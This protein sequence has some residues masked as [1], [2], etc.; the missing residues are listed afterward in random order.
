MDILILSGLA[1]IGHEL[2]KRTSNE[3]N[4]IKEKQ[5]LRKK[6]SYPIKDDNLHMH[7][8]K[9][10]KNPQETHVD[11]V[12]SSSASGDNIWS[13][14]GYMQNEDSHYNSQFMAINATHENLTPQKMTPFFS[15]TKV[16]NT[17]EDF[18]QRNLETFTGTNENVYKHKK[19]VE[20]LFKPK[21]MVFRGNQSNKERNERYKVSG[22][23]DG[24]SPIEKTYVGPGLN[25]DPSVNAKGGFH[26][27]FR[28][29]P[30]NQNSYTKQSFKG[31][32]V[33][34]KATTSSRNFT[35]DSISQNRPSSVYTLEERPVMGGMGNYRGAKTKENFN[36]SANNRTF[37]GD[38]QQNVHLNGSAQAPPKPIDT[39]A[40]FS[41]DKDD[42]NCNNYRT[43]IYSNIG[44][45]GYTVSKI[46]THDTDREMC[47]TVTN[48][49]NANAG[50]IYH[51]NNPTNRT[52]RETTESLNTGEVNVQMITNTT[53]EDHILGHMPNTT[54]KDTTQHANSNGFIGNSELSGPG[55]VNTNYN[56]YPTHRQGTSTEYGGIIKGNEETTNRNYSA[57]QT[58]R[59]GTS[60]D[61][62]GTASHVTNATIDKTFAE[63]SQ[64]YHKREDTL[65]G[66]APGPTNINNIDNPDKVINAEFK[67][68]NN[69]QQLNQAKLPNSVPD[70]QIIGTQNNIA[71]IDENNTRFDTS[72]IA[73]SNPYVQMPVKYNNQFSQ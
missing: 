60:K 3:T 38:V 36:I 64:S 39:N 27:S 49:Q 35:P 46:L 15:S 18:K 8:M 67:G 52:L 54:I 24:V 57:N 56:A 21:Q 33:A 53:P 61:Y 9:H 50:V 62:T 47:G 55:H 72:L 73:N 1:Y 37:D 71:R 6:N 19:E 14:N 25:L 11:Y 20:S 44:N 65:I 66:H 10:P 34:G 70:I 4:D 26:D 59:E 41:T 2:S 45:G 40:E 30:E 58:H 29:L 63:N 32:V 69:I 31:R 51:N 42:E 48:A 23:M 28:I 12:N 43:G 68:D 16:Q 17:N 5:I 7:K 13:V 22:K